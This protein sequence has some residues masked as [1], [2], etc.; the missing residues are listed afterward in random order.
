MPIFTNV[1]WG[2]SDGGTVNAANSALGGNNGFAAVTPGGVWTYRDENLSPDGPVDGRGYRASLPGGAAATYLRGDDDVVESPRGGARFWLNI[3]ATDPTADFEI[4]RA[5]PP[6]SIG[7]GAV[8]AIVARTDRKFQV[9][10]GTSN[11]IAASRSDALAAG[12]YCFEIIG[13]PDAE[14]V[15]FTIKNAAGATVHTWTGTGVTLPNPPGRYRFGTQTTGGTGGWATFELGSMIRWGSKASG[16]IGPG[17]PLPP[18]PP[19]PPTTTT[20]VSAYNTAEGLTDGTP[21]PLGGGTTGTEGMKFDARHGTVN[22][23][24]TDTDPIHGDRAYV[25]GAGSGDSAYVQ[26]SVATRRLSQRMYVRLPAAPGATTQIMNCRSDAG[27]VATVYLTGD[28]RIGMQNGLTEVSRTLPGVPTYPNAVIRVEML[29]DIDLGTIWAGWAVGDDGWTGQAQME[30]DDLG[31]MPLTMAH[32]GKCHGTSWDAASVVIDDLAINVV[33]PGPIGPYAAVY[34]IQP[35]VG[36]DLT[37]QEPGTWFTLTGRGDEEWEQIVGA[38]HPVVDLAQ[39]GSNATG[40]VPYTVDGPTL[41]FDFGGAVQRVEALASTARIVTAGGE[42]AL[43]ERVV[44]PDMP[45][46][47]PDPED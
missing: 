43:I 11:H 10:V 40:Q 26:W 5:I 42:V 20:R 14:R 1:G 21:A 33:P 39:T 15:D 12:W 6:A 4:F 28:G 13:D 7:S 32:F 36:D 34:T 2:N 25:L 47:L 44:M 16:P 27:R 35:S 22:V 8:M 24:V 38:G 46:P 41:E 29:T 9:L 31:D 45:P 23:T 3:P 17:E 18:E 30:F 37:R 19:P